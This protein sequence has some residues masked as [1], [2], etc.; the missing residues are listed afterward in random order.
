M[1]GELPNLWLKRE[2]A[3]KVS[4]WENLWNV[5]SRIKTMSRIDGHESYVWRHLNLEHKILF[6]SYESSPRLQTMCAER[7]CAENWVPNPLSLYVQ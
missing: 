1:V 4:N 2:R 6:E 5:E 3:S 7:L